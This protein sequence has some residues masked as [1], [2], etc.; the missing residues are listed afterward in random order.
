MIARKL[1]LVYDR[2]RSSIGLYSSTTFYL[3]MGILLEWSRGDSNP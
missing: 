2:P 3:Q 1:L